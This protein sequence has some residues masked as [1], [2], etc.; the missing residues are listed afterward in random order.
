MFKIRQPL[1]KLEF[2]L[3]ESNFEVLVNFR[4][5][6]LLIVLAFI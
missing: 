4:K 6:K 2:I 3:I 5:G 1:S